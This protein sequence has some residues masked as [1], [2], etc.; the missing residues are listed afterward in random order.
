[1]AL[2]GLSRGATD[3][4]VQRD[5]VQHGLQNLAIGHERE[6]RMSEAYAVTGIPAAAVVR[7]GLVVWRG[8]PAQLD[9]PTMTRL[10]GAAPSTTPCAPAKPF[11]KRGFGK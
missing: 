11:L 8:H 3:A 5:V 6:N 2:T 9:D 1:V 7:D 10:L 4:D